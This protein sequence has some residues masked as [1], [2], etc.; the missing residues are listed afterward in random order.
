MRLWMSRW[1]AAFLV[2]TGLVGGIVYSH[3]GIAALVPLLIGLSVWLWY[4]PEVKE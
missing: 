3:A 2:V 4:C 1:Y